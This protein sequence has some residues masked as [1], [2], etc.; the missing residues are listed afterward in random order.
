MFWCKGLAASKH[1]ISHWVRD[2]ISL[3][4]E[5]RSLPS[6]LDIRAGS[7]TLDPGRG[8][9]ESGGFSITTL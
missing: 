8:T 3:A 9:L 1:T 7:L 4:Y 5:V 6:P 2:A